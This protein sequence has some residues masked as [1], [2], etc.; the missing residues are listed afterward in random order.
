MN[1]P[2]LI[3]Y[4]VGAEQRPYPLGTRQASEELLKIYSEV[5]KLTKLTLWMPDSSQNLKVWVSSG[6]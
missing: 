2:T 1:N 5:Y 4:Q 3:T 6:I